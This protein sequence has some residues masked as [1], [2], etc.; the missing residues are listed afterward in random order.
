MIAVPQGVLV[1]DASIAPM[2]VIIASVFSTPTNSCRHCPTAAPVEARRSEE[3]QKA[4]KKTTY[5][6]ER[7]D[8]SSGKFNKKSYDY[9]KEL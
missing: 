3:A 7:K 1:T 4:Q 2:R 9:G 6:E 8:N 5:V